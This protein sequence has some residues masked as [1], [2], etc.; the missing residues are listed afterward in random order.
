MKKIFPLLL[1]IIVM[2]NNHVYS[3]S[4]PGTTWIVYDT[5]STFYN[6]FRFGTNTL[7]YS[8]NNVNYNTV[9][10][11][12]ENGNN[13][14]ITDIPGYVCY[15]DTGKYTFVMQNDSLKFTVVND[16]CP[17]R[18][19]V[20]EDYYWVKDISTEVA[21]SNSGSLIRIFPNPANEKIFIRSNTTEQGSEYI[22]SDLLGRFVLGGKLSDALTTIDIS[23]LQKGYYFIQ[24]GAKT[25]QSFKLIK[26]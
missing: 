2:R 19:L 12:V 15:P 9:S 11:F 26:E 4:L 25:R 5:T 14:S 13:F 3:Q 20:F 17:F 22:I 1:L 7:I 23:I 18:P 8:H 6:Y 21:D 24:I 16:T 10:T